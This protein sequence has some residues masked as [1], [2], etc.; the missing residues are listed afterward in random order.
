VVKSWVSEFGVIP[1]CPLK[2]EALE[3]LKS[4]VHALGEA[5][6][7]AFDDACA[8]AF[9][10]PFEKGC[11]KP[12]ANQEQEPEPKQDLKL[13]SG[14]PGTPLVADKSQPKASAARLSPHFEFPEA[15]RSWCRT[16]RPEVQDPATV[17]RK[18]VALYANGELKPIAGWFFKFRSFFIGERIEPTNGQSAPLVTDPDSRAN[19]EA[20]GI[21][22]GIG[23]WN[24]T[25]EQWA[26]YKARVLAAACPS[27]NLNAPGIGLDAL[28]RLA[29]KR[30]AA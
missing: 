17:F 28:N 1:E 24:E 3:A 27:T 15:W 7:K 13:E 12:L 10:K 23:K 20:L 26:P 9:G 4:S 16:S 14:A 25:S 19:V 21:A 29:Q 5:F 2:W 30:K 6:G 18:F 22:K 11:P 8:K